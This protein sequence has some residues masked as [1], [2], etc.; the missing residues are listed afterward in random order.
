MHSRA[1]TA[2]FTNI[3]FLWDTLYI[4]RNF[5]QL[6]KTDQNFMFVQP[7]KLSIID[8]N[9]RL[10]DYFDGIYWLALYWRWNLNAIKIFG[11]FEDNFPNLAQ[12]LHIA[13]KMYRLLFLTL[14]MRVFSKF[15]NQKWDTFS[16]TLLNFY[17]L[18]L[19]FI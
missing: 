3:P 10:L 1:N 13:L 16:P 8:I 18:T 14:T 12:S 17:A 11:K 9:V 19:L 4:N 6:D 2:T 15:S 7:F 5:P